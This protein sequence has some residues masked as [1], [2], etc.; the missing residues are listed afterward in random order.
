MEYTLDRFAQ[1]VED[2]Q[3]YFSYLR[4]FGEAVAVR[5]EKA[6]LELLLPEPGAPYHA[7]LFRVGKKTFWIIYTIEGAIVSRRRPRCR[8]RDREPT[9]C[10]ENRPD[11]VHGIPHTAYRKR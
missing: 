2:Y 5:F 9:G 6:L 3:E 1:F 10:Y 11:T 7:K 4:E 8:A